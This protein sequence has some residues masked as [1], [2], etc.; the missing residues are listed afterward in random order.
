M[1]FGDGI[2]GQQTGAA[3][4]VSA[5][6]H[7]GFNP[8]HTDRHA[9]GGNGIST[10]QVACLPCHYSPTMQCDKFL[11]NIYTVLG[12]FCFQFIYLKV[13]VT[14]REGET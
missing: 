3:T 9:V 2:L 13:R 7:P 10:E 12:A 6:P 1:G 14:E 4:L 5:V 8:P 11:H